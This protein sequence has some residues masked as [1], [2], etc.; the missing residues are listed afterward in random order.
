[1]LPAL[2]KRQLPGRLGPLL[3]RPVSVARVRANSDL[4]LKHDPDLAE[5]LA[6]ETG[7]ALS[8]TY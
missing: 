2:V 4:R 3:H 7:C 5:R 1:M 6:R 8:W